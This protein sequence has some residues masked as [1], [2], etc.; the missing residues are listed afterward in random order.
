M[1]DTHVLTFEAA[2]KL[3][4]VASVDTSRVLIA[5]ENAALLPRAAVGS[6]V[7]IQGLTAQEFLIGMTE[8]VTRELREQTGQPD[9]LSPTTL[10]TEFVPDD[11]IRIALLGTYYYARERT[12]SGY[13]TIRLAGS[14]SSQI[15]CSDRGKTRHSSG[16][17]LGSTIG[18]SS[19]R[20]GRVRTPAI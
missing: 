5:V 2:S 4:K 16:R 1:S 20:H 7:A 10:T 17:F 13:A 8:R 9:P 14:S 15:A 3:G 11:T 18:Y 19:R 6:L 12:E